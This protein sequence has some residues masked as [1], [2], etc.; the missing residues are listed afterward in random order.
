MGWKNCATMHS[1]EREK[2]IDVAALFGFHEFAVARASPCVDKSRSIH[3]V[4]PQ[5]SFEWSNKKENKKTAFSENC[6]G[7]TPSCV[8]AHRR[9]VF[10]NK[11]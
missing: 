7:P 6:S 5:H 2:E 8:R 9:K 3:R 1:V 11:L 4:E 10:A